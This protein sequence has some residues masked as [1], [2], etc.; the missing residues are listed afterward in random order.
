MIGSILLLPELDEGDFLF[1]KVQRQTV[2]NR[3]LNSMCRAET[4]HKTL[5]AVPN[6]VVSTLG[7]SQLRYNLLD[8][9]SIPGLSPIVWYPAGLSLQEAAVWVA[10]TACMD[11]VVVVPHTSWLIQP[12]HIDLLVDSLHA[13][14]SA[15]I[16][17]GFPLAFHAFGA[18][19]VTLSRIK[20]YK[21]VE[22]ELPNAGENS[23]HN[24]TIDTTD[25]FVDNLIMELDA[26]ADVNDILDDWR[27]H[28]EGT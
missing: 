27:I 19:F 23:V 11:K 20:D 1:K 15:A 3:V 10:R 22:L 26:G 16:S 6:S 21:R 25:P 18:D 4:V 5:V 9:P 2:L 12:W 14:R 7:G 8:L 17:D 24:N 13:N 28:R